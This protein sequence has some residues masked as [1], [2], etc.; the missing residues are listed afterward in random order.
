MLDVPVVTPRRKQEPLE[1]RTLV[2]GVA[3]PQASRA[4]PLSDLART[5]PV[6]DVLG[7][8]EIVVMPFEEG[9]SVRVFDR[10]VGGQ[11]LQFFAGQA[12]NAGHMVDTPTGTTWDLTGLALSGPL[13]GRRLEKLGVL[14]DYWFDWKTYHPDTDVYRA[15]L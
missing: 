10:K 8:R 12:E 14:L 6:N 11:L 1:D 15:G 9:S 3:L 7:G 2:A 13:S 5:G 4:Y